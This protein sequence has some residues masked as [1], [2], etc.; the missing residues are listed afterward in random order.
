MKKAYLA[1]ILGLAFTCTANAD[2]KVS[3]KTDVKEDVGADG[4]V[5]KSSS[6]ETVDA[7]GTKVKS[8]LD[9]K[10]KVKSDGTR[11][12]SS[13]LSSTTDPKGLG[14]KTTAKR[15][16]NSTED[17][18]GSF[19]RNTESTSVDAA[20][21]AHK[22]TVERSVDQKSDGTAKSTHKEKVVNDPKGLMNKTTEETERTVTRD[23]DG[24]VITDKADKTVDGKRVQ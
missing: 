14:N 18:R 9:E 7:A 1:V 21:T 24:N 11:K 15:T 17:G 5:K 13:V 20:G 23:A 2:S 4:T 3:Y 8:N 19:D 22:K 16:I 6:E 10:S 12:T